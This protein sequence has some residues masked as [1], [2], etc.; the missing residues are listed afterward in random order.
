MFSCR[1]RIISK[2]KNKNKKRIKSF[3]A[4]RFQEPSWKIRAVRERNRQG[5]FQDDKK[6]GECCEQMCK[7]R[8]R[9][10]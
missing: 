1:R 5:V 8:A 9:S 7:V 10:S 6:R 4:E 3:F 2:N